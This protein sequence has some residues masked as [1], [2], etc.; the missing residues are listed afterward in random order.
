MLG[1][2][3]AVLLHASTQGTGDST[4]PGRRCWLQPFAGDQGALGP[5][6]GGYNRDAEVTG[7]DG[8]GAWDEARMAPM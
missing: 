7:A 3:K 8:H 5:H 2:K 1:E 6:R 4:G